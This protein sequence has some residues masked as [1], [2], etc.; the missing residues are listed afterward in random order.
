MGPRDMVLCAVQE[1]SVKHLSLVAIAFVAMFVL[2][3]VLPSH[4]VTTVV[5]QQTQA[6]QN[7]NVAKIP[8]VSV[9]NYFKYSADMNLGEVLGV[10][11]NSKGHVVV[12]NHPGTST[13][14]PVY[15][16]ATTQ[17]FEFDATGKFVREIGHGVYGFA[18]VHSVRFDKYDN[19]WAVDKAAHTVVKFT[20]AGYVT[21]NLGRRPEGP[22]DPGGLYFRGN[23]LGRGGEGE[24]GF[25]APVHVDGQFRGSTDVAW[26]SDD[27]IYV[28]DGYINSRVAKFDKHGNWIKS[29][30][31]RGRSGEHANENPSQ[32]NTPHNIGI[33]RRN[34]V[35]VADRGNRRIQVFDRDGNFQRFIFLNA[36]YDKSR[37]PVLGNLSANPP[38]ETQPWTICITNGPTQYLY[39]S[40]SEPGRIY[41]LSLDGKILGMFGESGHEL[42]QFSWTHAIACP[43]ED[44]L[45][46]ADMNNWR[47][48]KVLLNGAKD[49]AVA[50]AAA[51]ALAVKP[52][53]KQ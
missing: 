9:P 2:A 50:A 51:A 45:Y 35:Y 14:G 38:D 23:G 8:F 40:D 26:D 28:S 16:N 37:H 5:A 3:P 13:A 29:W 33:D 4:P 20:P 30:G 19:L 24:G 15:G 1:G 49:P 47:V 53:A 21:M 27:N 34:N 11:V 7:N 41:K 31:S 46:I 18:Y 12:L 10:A 6:I 43:S 36:P 48:Q 17:L 52:G 32:F 42:G 39:T 22:D 25:P 44:V